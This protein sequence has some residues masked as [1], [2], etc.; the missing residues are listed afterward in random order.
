[1]LNFYTFLIQKMIIFN[2]KE[3]KAQS[4]QKSFFKYTI[5]L[6]LHKGHITS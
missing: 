2:I 4:D 1:M 3:T 6:S 5:D